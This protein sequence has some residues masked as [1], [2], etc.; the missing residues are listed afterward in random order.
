MHGV[1]AYYVIADGG[2]AR[3]VRPSEGHHFLTIREI[4]SSHMHHRS[5][6]LGSAPPSRV[7]ESA[8]PTRHG[9]EPRQDPHDRAEREFAQYVAKELN[10]DAEISAC[11]AL[12]LVAPSHTLAD[13]R[14]ALSRQLQ[15]KIVTTLA[16][17]LTKVPDADL[18]K[19][20]PQPS[21]VWRKS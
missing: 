13:L 21:P 11:D 3:F 10:G 6:E 18:P 9:V 12:I 8:S 7:Q 17:D 16:K 15:A 4:E 20:L 2:R 1:T 14:P 5:H 19:H